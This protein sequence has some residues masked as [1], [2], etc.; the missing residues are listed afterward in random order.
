[1]SILIGATCA[2]G[3]HVP[4]NVTDGVYSLFNYENG[5]EVHTHQC[6]FGCQHQSL[7]ASCKFRRQKTF[8]D[9][10]QALL[11]MKKPRISITGLAMLLFFGLSI[12]FQTHYGD[13]WFY[14]PGSARYNDIAPGTSYSCGYKSYYR[15][16]DIALWETGLRECKIPQRWY[17]S[18]GWELN[19]NG[20]DRLR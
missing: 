1:M 10:W 19:L 4:T 18:L 9:E 15:A 13:M 7:V 17:S 14:R 8:L 3:F 5:T 12:C 11:L 6:P 16:R 20:V 2:V